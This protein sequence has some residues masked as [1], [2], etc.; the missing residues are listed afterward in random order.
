[1]YSRNS[2][3]TFQEFARHYIGQHRPQ[4]QMTSMP[5]GYTYFYGT[6]T[7][8][9]YSQPQYS[10]YN[11]SSSNLAQTGVDILGAGNPVSNY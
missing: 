8:S 11:S 10:S 1:M 4:Q 3:A 5:F 7:N 6:P 9:Q 2:N